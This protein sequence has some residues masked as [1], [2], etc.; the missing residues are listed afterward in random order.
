[1]V[2]DES[3]HNKPGVRKSAQET[4]AARLVAIP[5]I[6]G[7]AKHGQRSELTVPTVPTALSSLPIPPPS[8]APTSAGTHEFRAQPST[9]KGTPNTTQDTMPGLLLPGESVNQYTEPLFDVYAK[10]YVPSGLRAINE[11]V[12]GN[13]PLP[14]QNTRLDLVHII[15]NLPREHAAKEHENEQHALCRVPLQAVPMPDLTRLWALSVTTWLNHMIPYCSRHYLRASAFTSELRARKTTSSNNN[16]DS[17]TIID[18]CL[19]PKL[20]M[21][22]HYPYPDCGKTLRNAPHRTL[23][24][25]AINYAQA[26]AVNSICAA[27]YGTLPY[28]ISGPPGTGKT[29]TLIGVAMQLPNT[30]DVAHMLLCAPSE[31]TADTLAMRLKQYLTPKQFLRLNGPNRADNEVSRELLQYCYIQDGM[32]Y[33]P[34][35]KTLLSYSVIV[36]SCCD[37]VIMA[38]ARLTNAD[39][40]TM[41]RAL[42]AALHFEE[43]PP[44]PFLHWGALLLDE[45]AQVTEVDVLPAISIICPPSAYPQD[46]AQPRLVMAGGE[47]Q[48]GP[49]TASHDSAFSTSLF[50]RFFARPLYANHP[51]YRSNVRPSSGPSSKPRRL[52]DEIKRDNG[53]WYNISEARLACFLYWYSSPV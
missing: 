10:S 24:D 42:V 16:T 40:W 28:L 3:N 41:E 13:I 30:T 21:Q 12:A 27:D 2:L 19:Q 38:E 46:H 35:F 52:A 31:A 51:L 8:S 50:A 32:F 25:Y 1:M 34:P 44:T 6:P 26:R 49:R 36:T 43:E 17:N 53:G 23:F 22:L 5:F 4:A 11:E 48:L 39:L 7:S 15:A 29:K 9:C 37:A 45:A 47:H 14:K 20:L 33:I 18:H